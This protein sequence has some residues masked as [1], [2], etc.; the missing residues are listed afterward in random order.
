MVAE[1]SEL[2]VL[3]LCETDKRGIPIYREKCITDSQRSRITSP[4]AFQQMDRSNYQYHGVENCVAC[5]GKLIVLTVQRHGP[6][7]ESRDAR[8][9]H[10]TF[11]GYPYACGVL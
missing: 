4:V 9:A 8:S 11:N 7:R 3:G 5:V 10:D 2:R 1:K 6:N